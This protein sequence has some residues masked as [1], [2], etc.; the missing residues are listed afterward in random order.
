MNHGRTIRISGDIV[1]RHA[2]G[3]H[4]PECE[5]LLLAEVFPR[6]LTF[7]IIT[8]WNQLHSYQKQREQM[9]PDDDYPHMAA[10]S[11]GHLQKSVVDHFSLAPV[12]F[13]NETR[14]IHNV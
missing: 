1:L 13:T 10:S 4:V 2:K 8:N 14:F 3:I 9:K 11:K 5:Q 6:L 12:L 7:W